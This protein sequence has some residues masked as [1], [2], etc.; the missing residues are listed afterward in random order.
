VALTTSDAESCA[1]A[2]E[3]LIIEKIK[4]NENKF[5]IRPPK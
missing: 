1:N 3:L 4:I 5:F 2:S